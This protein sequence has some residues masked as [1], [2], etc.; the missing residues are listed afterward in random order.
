MN[1]AGEYLFGR[2]L[3]LHESPWVVR[4]LDEPMQNRAVEIALKQHLVDRGATQG[5]TA[6]T[7]CTPP[8]AARSDSVGGAILIRSIRLFA[9][10]GV[11]VATRLRPGGWPREWREEF[12]GGGMNGHFQ[13]RLMAAQ[14]IDD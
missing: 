12:T 2:H 7:Q 1:I 13:L 9:D 11:L 5:V 8:P 4:C 6:D 10:S 3:R 14:P